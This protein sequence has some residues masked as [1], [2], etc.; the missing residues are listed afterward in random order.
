VEKLAPKRR[1][2]R[3]TRGSYG[4]HN[5]SA[6]DSA[7]RESELDLVYPAIGPMSGDLLVL[8]ELLVLVVVVGAVLMCVTCLRTII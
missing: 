5:R 6:G 2:V 1:N 3:G 7:Q 8:A 4:L